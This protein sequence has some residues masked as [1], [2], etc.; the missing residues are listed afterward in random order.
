MGRKYFLKKSFAE[1]NNGACVVRDVHFGLHVDV[2]EAVVYVADMVRFSCWD[3]DIYIFDECGNFGG[4]IF[5]RANFR[6]FF[7]RVEFFILR[8]AV[9][10]SGLLLYVLALPF[11][12]VVNGV[13]LDE[14]ERKYKFPAGKFGRTCTADNFCGDRI[15]II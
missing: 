9:R 14:L 7:L 3:G 5:T 10:A 13:V 8:G 6:A 12:R 1:F 4:E 11:A 15:F 2:S